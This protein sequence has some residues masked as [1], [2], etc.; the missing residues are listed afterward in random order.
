VCD[1]IIWDYHIKK[2]GRPENISGTNMNKN[3][4]ILIAIVSAIILIVGLT[5]FF[6]A[7]KNKTV[8]LQIPTNPTQSI[9]SNNQYV[10]ISTKSWA[11][12]AWLS[13]VDADK[14]ETISFVAT[15][16]NIVAEK[17]WAFDGI[18]FYFKDNVI[19]IAAGEMLKITGSLNGAFAD[20]HNLK[21]IT[22]LE[23]IDTS[24]V[25]D[26]SNM[27][28]NCSSLQTLPIKDL[29]TDGVILASSMFQGCASLT[30][31]DL[32]TLNMQNAIDMSNL[33]AECSSLA[34][35]IVP[36]TRDVQTL[37][38]A[39]KSIGNGAPYGSVIEGYLNT[40]KCEDMSNMF[41]G[42]QFK[43]YFIA[44]KFDTASLKN[45]QGMFSHCSII[46]LDL[47]AWNTSKLET[48]KD[49]FAYSSSMKKC[50]LNGW[51]M[52]SLINCES[53]FCCCNNLESFALGWKNVNTVS[54]AA[55]LFKY[56]FSLESMD[57]SC[58][59]GVKIGNA[60]EMFYDCEYLSTIY[61]DGFDADVSDE[62]FKYCISLNNYAEDKMTLN[63]AM[64][65]GYFNKQ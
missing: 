63:D 12:K 58:F 6:I 57:I 11:N 46:E 38:G 14:I 45:A 23:R 32:S 55:S 5:I 27:F 49:M 15:N 39:F 64:E 52:S 26:M 44:E 22:G 53:M 8:E 4:K 36:Q 37:S 9:Q 42:A 65:L 19:Y 41:Y 24:E 3:G 29:K 33:L 21:E 62:M 47:S 16:D 48:T 2:G 13:L 10:K 17:A 31:L 1:A 25:R 56:C 20:L 61:C 51:D 43:D 40:G 59:N 60:R 30:K 50:N 35:I 34:H 18:G 28:K 7:Q 54:S